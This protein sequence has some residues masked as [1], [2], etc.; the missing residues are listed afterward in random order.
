MYFSL[1]F[2]YVPI[3]NAENKHFEMDIHMGKWDDLLFCHVC[4]PITKYITSTHNK[5]ELLVERNW[6]AIWL[7]NNMNMYGFF[8]SLKKKCY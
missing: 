5:G 3:L 7:I 2:I 6:H 1:P 4:I 8:K